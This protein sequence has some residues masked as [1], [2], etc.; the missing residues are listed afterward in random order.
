MHHDYIL[1]EIEALTRFLA[2][3]LFQKQ[4]E[5]PAIFDQQG[6][7]SHQTFLLHRLHLLVQDGKVNQ[8]ENL[9]FDTIQEN[10]SS[11]YL[12]AAIDFYDMLSHMSD[13][14]LEACDFSRQ[15]IAEGLC[16]IKA[17]F[18]V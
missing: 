4:T 16:E 3:T 6:N 10:P 18:Q 13:Q 8:A 1:R 2:N 9:L 11:E 12:K 14:Q 17:M 7:L 5:S 15:E